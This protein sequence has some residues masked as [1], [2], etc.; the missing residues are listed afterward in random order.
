MNANMFINS[1]EIEK[2]L[3]HY[4][5]QIYPVVVKSGKFK[6]NSGGSYDYQSHGPVQFMMEIDFKDKPKE[7]SVD[8]E[9]KL[10]PQL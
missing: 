5:E 1:T 8:M 4:M 6:T 2:I 3:I 10:D 9:R 7:V